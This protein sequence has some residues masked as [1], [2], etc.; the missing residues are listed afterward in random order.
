MPA[1]TA[2]TVLAGGI[3]LLGGII[4]VVDGFIQHSAFYFLGIGGA[5]LLVAGFVDGTKIRYRGPGTALLLTF[6]TGQYA[7]KWLPDKPWGMTQ[8]EFLGFCYATL[9][10]VYGFYVLLREAMRLRAQPPR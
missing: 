5:T 2:R 10:A 3:L 8:L 9:F 4:G 7:F 1:A 6:L